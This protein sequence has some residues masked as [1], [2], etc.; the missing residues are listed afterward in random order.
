LKFAAFSKE[1][2]I[3]GPSMFENE[4]QREEFRPKKLKDMED[5]KFL[6][7]SFKFEVFTSYYQGDYFKGDQ[8]EE[9][10]RTYGRCDILYPLF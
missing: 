10:C 8:M 4:V 9:I 7:R 3:H 5:G 6:F 2:A 1:L